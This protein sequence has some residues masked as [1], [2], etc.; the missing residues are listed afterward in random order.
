[1][2]EPFLS[3]FERTIPFFLLLKLRILL[4]LSNR[5]SPSVRSVV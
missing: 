5:P 3:T 1:M 2:S 4:G